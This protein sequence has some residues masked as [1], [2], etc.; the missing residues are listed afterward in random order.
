MIVG[1]CAL[2]VGSAAWSAP[3]LEAFGKLPALDLVRLSPSGDKIAFV[4]VD[5]ETRR[6][7]IRKVGGEAL[8]VNTV[9]SGKV[10]DL[11]WA[12]DDYVLIKASA[13]V[14]LGN[15]ALDKWSYTTRADLTV[16]LIANLN[17]RTIT[18]MF[19]H[20]ELEV[21]FAAVD[22]DYGARLIDGR[23]Y[24]FVHAFTNNHGG[25][26][27]KVDL[28]TGKYSI[29]TAGLGDEFGYVVD[30]VGSIAARTRYDVISKT[31]RLYTGV[32]GTRAA[33]SRVSPLST[34][35]VTSL[36]RTD[37]TVLV[38]DTNDKE[39][40]WDEY[41][42]QAD[43]Q[44]TR[45]FE[46]K[47]IDTFL[48]DPTTELLIGALE[49]DGQTAIFFDPK[50]Q[51]RFDAV[52][53]A[54]PG[55][56][57]TLESYSTDMARMVVMT[58][59][60]DDAGTYWIIDMTTG[61]ADELMA[62]YPAIGPKDV[63]P[64]RMFAYQAA[65]GLP[66]EGVLT[67]PP[68]LPAKALPLVV[69]PHGGPID[70]RDRV[71]FDWWAQAFASRGYAVFQPNYRGSSGYGAPFREKGMGEWG[72]RMLT[73][74]SDGIDALTRAG[75][76][77]NDRVCIV[78]ASYGG[79]A[80]LAGV[81]VQHGLYRCAVSV[82]GVSDVSAMMASD[83][84]NDNYPSGRYT[85]K[86]FG[87]KSASDGAL[88]RISPLLHPDQADAPILLIHGK[89]DTVVPF[90]HSLTMNDALAKAGKTT[91][92]IAMDGEDHF[93]SREVTRVQTLEASVNWVEKYNPPIK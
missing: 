84:D 25:N 49:M 12:G 79:Y 90:V 74:M 59:G 6:L 34:V 78:G 72:R 14:K 70:V 5:G 20:K 17:T 42:I 62:A 1:I 63:G 64:T 86:L 47:R 69:M 39:D 65:D 52:K 45:L 81:T 9:G 7:F 82:A 35:G 28:D 77:D 32:H 71:G 80:A 50:L 88:E 91:Q 54:F 26:I 67:L 30:A 38:G 89:D 31:W 60:G 11:E 55:Y 51:R 24:E 18:K 66:L 57:V 36:G 83:G 76:V 93:L 16:V 27:Y 53:K 73:D 56:Q 48:F 15:G 23:W 87:V 44:P 10:R 92:L 22:N 85:Q 4:A 2:A 21:A 46:G 8:L 29:V 19:N 3:P 58:D 37:G 61:K 13:T 41:P 43:A 33:I 75:I 68:G 40:F